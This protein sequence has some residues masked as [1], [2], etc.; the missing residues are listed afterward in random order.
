MRIRII[1]LLLLTSLA[2]GAAPRKNLDTSKS[3]VNSSDKRSSS[4]WRFI[5]DG[6]KSP[7]K[8]ITWQKQGYSCKAQ[9]INSTGELS[10]KEITI[11]SDK[12]VTVGSILKRVETSLGLP[13]VYNVDSNNIKNI[14]T[15]LPVYKVYSPSKT[16]D[17]LTACAIWVSGKILY[18]GDPHK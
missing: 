3:D 17:Y 8:G 7:I 13:R 16:N 9:K 11:Q 12:Q 18:L 6:K 1:S 14:G 4:E 2:A 10:G 5:G 15:S